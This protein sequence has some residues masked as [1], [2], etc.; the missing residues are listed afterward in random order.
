[1]SDG[2]PDQHRARPHVEEPRAPIESQVEPRAPSAGKWLSIAW[3][4]LAGSFLLVA[5]RS[6]AVWSDSFFSFSPALRALLFTQAARWG[7]SLLGG[8]LLAAGSWEVAA[9][10]TGRRT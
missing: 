9:F 2:P 8:V 7:I 1:M 6:G 10:L 3:L 5:P 4:L